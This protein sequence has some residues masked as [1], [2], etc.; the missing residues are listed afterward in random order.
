MTPPT[1]HD[2]T[3]AQTVEIVLALIIGVLVC[4]SVVLISWLLR[5]VIG[6]DGGGAWAVTTTAVAIAAGLA[7]LAR[8]L[9]RALRQR[10]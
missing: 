8:Q 6:T 5:L 9:V 4:L 10:L 7:A 2:R 3:E 1:G